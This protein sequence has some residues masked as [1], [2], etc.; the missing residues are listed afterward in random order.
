[1]SMTMSQ[2]E[3]SSKAAVGAPLT[4][5]WYLALL[6]SEVTSGSMKAQTLLGMPPV[7]CRGN[8]G[9]LAALRDICPHRAMP[10]SFGCFDGQRIECFYHGWQFANV[11]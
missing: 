3:A 5:F 2:S 10:L 6:S 1:M 7:I 11:F 8:E 4:G 9:K